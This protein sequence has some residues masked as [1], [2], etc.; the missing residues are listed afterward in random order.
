MFK[1]MMSG[2]NMQGVNVET[3]LYNPTLQAGET[4]RGEINFTG[5]PTN[6]E[7]NFTA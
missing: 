4:L 6:K 3:R 7:I 2:L 5:G 1:K